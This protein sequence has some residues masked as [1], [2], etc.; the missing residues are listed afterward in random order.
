MTIKSK[1]AN[2]SVAQRLVV[3]LLCS[4][5]TDQAVDDG[6]ERAIDRCKGHRRG[7]RGLYGAWCGN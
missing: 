3:L 2:S 4:V 5:G 6:M 7:Y 1:L